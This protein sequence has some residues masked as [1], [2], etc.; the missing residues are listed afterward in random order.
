MAMASMLFKLRLLDPTAAER[1]LIHR[2]RPSIR[3][4]RPSNAR[5]SRASLGRVRARG[6]SSPAVRQDKLSLASAI[7]PSVDGSSGGG[8]GADEAHEAR[9]SPTP[10]ASAPVEVTAEGEGRTSEA[11]DTPS[12]D[13]ILEGLP[14][15]RFSI[16]SCSDA[17]SERPDTASEPFSPP[18]AGERNTAPAG[19]GAAMSR[20]TAP[21]LSR[22]AADGVSHY[23]SALPLPAERPKGRRRSMELGGAGSPPRL[24]RVAT[25]CGGDRFEFVQRQAN[26]FLQLLL[27][28]D[29]G[30]SG[31]LSYEEWARGVL[32]LPEVL[33]CFQL[34][35]APPSRAPLSIGTRAR[36]DG[37][38]LTASGRPHVHTG[39]LAATTSSALV[40]GSEHSISLDAVNRSLWWRSLWNTLAQVTCT[41]CAQ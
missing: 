6:H 24:R 3:P 39:P 16:G 32:S 5:S 14:S 17:G 26:E 2:P 21:P 25:V 34:V 35:I 9:N 15:G 33:S 7:V 12:L 31:K 28:M 11:S 36:T 1:P 30:R 41:S 22:H 23:G 37:H 29:V 8:E 19:G 38:L 20:S 18:P 27:V 40:R 4:T 10:L 13:L